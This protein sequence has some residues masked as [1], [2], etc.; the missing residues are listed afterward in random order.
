MREIWILRLG[1]RVPRDQRVSTHLALAARALGASK[2]FYTGVR[3][4]EFE[5][6]IDRVR[7][8]WGG[9]FRLEYIED[10]IDFIM[11]VR[12]MGFIIIHL[13]MYGIPLNYILDE[14]LKHEKFL[15]IV[16]GEKVPS[17]YFHI[18]DFNVAIGGQPHSEISALAIFLDRIFQGA[19]LD[20]HFS[21]GIYRVVSSK[22]GKY[23]INIKD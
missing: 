1:H 14:L 22:K 7:R 17:E 18:S 8:N 23:P 10:P 2:M 11:N 21:G 16:G 6:S 13:T 20:L 15:V 9:E 4:P 12:S 3:D 19:E 5:G